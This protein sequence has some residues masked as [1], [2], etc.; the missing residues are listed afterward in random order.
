MVG[1]EFFHILVIF[2][3]VLLVTGWMIGVCD[4]LFNGRFFNCL[5]EKKWMVVT[6]G[7]LLLIFVARVWYIILFDVQDIVN[8]IFGLCGCSPIDLKNFR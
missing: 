8:N 6:I 4:S 3:S 5:C 2:V 1:M 7:V